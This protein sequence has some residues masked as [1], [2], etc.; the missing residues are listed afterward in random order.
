MNINFLDIFIEKKKT[1]T[2]SNTSHSMN[3]VGVNPLPPS[4][5]QMNSNNLNSFCSSSLSNSNN[6][7][8]FVREYADCK[9]TGTLTTGEKTWDVLDCCTQECSN[10]RF[11]KWPKCKCT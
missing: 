5:L 4:I 1:M 8:P 7:K 3:V 10:Y 9:G 6:S 2:L 11:L